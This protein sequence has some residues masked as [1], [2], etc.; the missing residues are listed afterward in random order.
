MNP[1]GRN[2]LAAICVLLVG[3]VAAGQSGRPVRQ[4]LYDA[5]LTPSTPPVFERPASGIP[6]SPPQHD[7][8]Q[9]DQGK[10]S[11]TRLPTASPSGVTVAASTVLVVGLFLLAAWLMRRGMPRAAGR[12]SPEVVEVLGHAPLAGR[13]QVRLVKFGN[14]LV[15]LASSATGSE[16]IAEITDRAEVERLVALCRPMAHAPQEPADVD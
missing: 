11:T 13:Q 5:P 12:L 10:R 9:A 8:Q 1:L 14:K 15:L 6:L 2:L 3:G 16:P 7:V 4:A